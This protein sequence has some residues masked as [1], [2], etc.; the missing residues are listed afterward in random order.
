MEKSGRIRKDI[1]GRMMK[2][3]LK[4]IANG[5]KKYIPFNKGIYSSVVLIL[6]ISDIFVIIHFKHSVRRG[7]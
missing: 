6:F 1:A 5:L 7:R 2:D 4:R 3:S